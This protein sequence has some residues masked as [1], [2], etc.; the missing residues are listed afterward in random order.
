[1]HASDPESATVPEEDEAVPDDEPDD[2]PEELPVMPDDE[3]EEPPE[4]LPAMPDDEPEALSVDES[5][6]VPEDEPE[7]EPEE[8]PEFPPPLVLLEHPAATVAAEAPMP[9]T[10]ITWKSFLVVFKVSPGGKATTHLFR[11]KH[12]MGQPACPRCQGAQGAAACVPRQSWVSP[13]MTAA[14]ASAR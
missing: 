12:P 9:T 7:A 3:P 6:S 8:D 5:A 10:T 13:S 1:M 14:V 4:E 11:G 2:E